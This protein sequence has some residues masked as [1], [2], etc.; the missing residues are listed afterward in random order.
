MQTFV[1]I[2]FL[3]LIAGLVVQVGFARAFRARTTRLVAR[4]H[5]APQIRPVAGLPQPVQDFALRA[6]AGKGGRLR[7]ATLT[8]SGALRTA[9][10]GAFAPFSAW[11]VIALGA[12]GFVWLARQDWGPFPKLRI[13]DAYVGREGCLEARIMG[14]VPVA[15][16]SGPS[17][18]L[19]EA[20]RYLA[21]L[22]WAPDA[23]LGNPDLEW[24]LLARNIAEVR[25]ATPEG[26]ARVSFRFDA[27]GDIVE[28]EAKGR[29]ALDAAGKEERLDW[30]GFFRDY[31]QIGPR[32]IPSAAEV[33]YVHAEGYEAYF[34]CTVTDYRLAS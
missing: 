25:L 2:V 29:P 19:G 23:I 6:G 30:R 17:L 34:R 11:Q 3:V 9:R 10:G 5:A 4:L 1:A 22:P 16:A 20:Y 13:A 8:Q 18:N 12:P 26:A 24:R 21:E 27:A 31:R 28:M 14:S 32:R 33:G 15:R 7:T